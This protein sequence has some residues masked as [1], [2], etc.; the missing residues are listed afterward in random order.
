MAPAAHAG[1]VHS[2]S[3]GGR[4]QGKDGGNCE[5]IRGLE[6]ETAIYRERL[7]LGLATKMERWSVS[8]DAGRTCAGEREG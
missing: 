7:S 4:I 2:P 8:R 3:K 6:A 1:R 5:E